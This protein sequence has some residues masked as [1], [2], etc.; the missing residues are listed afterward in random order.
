MMLWVIV[1]SIVVVFVTIALK[2][3]SP[4]FLLL[5]I[6]VIGWV[7]L[8]VYLLCRPQRDRMKHGENVLQKWGWHIAAISLFSTSAL[9]FQYQAMNLVDPSYVMSVKRMDVLMT[10]LLAGLFLHEK[11]ILQRFRGSVIAVIGVVIILVAG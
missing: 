11:H 1:T 2:S 5:Y 9:F 7:I 4:S 6:Q 3:A 10:V 8:S